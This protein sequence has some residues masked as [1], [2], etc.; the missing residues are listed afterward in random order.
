ML[1]HKRFLALQFINNRLLP[2]LYMGEYSSLPKVVN[3]CDLLFI[4]YLLLP[5]HPPQTV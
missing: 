4:G 1:C 3:V 5:N 2:D